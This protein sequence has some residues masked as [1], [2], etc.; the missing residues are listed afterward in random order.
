LVEQVCRLDLVGIEEQPGVQVRTGATHSHQ[1]SD[2]PCHDQIQGQGTLDAFDRAQ[3][4]FLDLAAVLQDV[5]QHF[6]FPAGAIPVDQLGHLGHA[7]GGAVGQQAPFDRLGA[8][9]GAVFARDDAGNRQR[10]AFAR[11]QFD[12]TCPQFLAH[13]ACLGAGPS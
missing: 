8:G 2:A 4:K 11:L 12:T 9:R 13:D 3:L 7:G 1:V 5:E 10:R 6:D